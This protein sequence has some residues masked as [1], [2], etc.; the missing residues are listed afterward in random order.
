MGKGWEWVGKVCV[1]IGYLYKTSHGESRRLRFK[2][3]TE[4]VG[5]IVVELV[6]GWVGFECV[7]VFVDNQMA[8]A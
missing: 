8:D 1:V 7:F 2:K 5:L 3:N 6:S 4:L